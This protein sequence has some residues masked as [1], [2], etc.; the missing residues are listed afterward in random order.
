LIRSARDH[1]MVVILDPRFAHQ[2]LR[3]AIPGKPARVPADDRIGGRRG[4][5]GRRFASCKGA[6]ARLA[7]AVST[8]SQSNASGLAPGRESFHCLHQFG[9][10]FFRSSLPASVTRVPSRI[11]SWSCTKPSRCGQSGR[12]LLASPLRSRAERLGALGDAAVRRR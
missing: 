2:A 12:R 9:N 11:N 7:G 6:P 10:A 8:C 5:W 3:Q 1:G 4:V